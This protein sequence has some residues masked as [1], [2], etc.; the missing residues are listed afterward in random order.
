MD[1]GRPFR[2][3]LSSAPI[4][5]MLQQERKQATD[6]QDPHFMACFQLRDNRDY[7]RRTTLACNFKSQL[8]TGG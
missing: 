1:E 4:D 5:E 2:K 8:A 6:A 3:A 7:L